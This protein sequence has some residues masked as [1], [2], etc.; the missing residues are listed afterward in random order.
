MMGVP[1]G[2]TH[3]ID[4]PEKRNIIQILVKEIETRIAKKSNEGEINSRT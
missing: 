1:R 2:R 3:F 4:K